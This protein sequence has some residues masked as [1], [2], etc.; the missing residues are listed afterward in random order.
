MAI[1]FS[2]LWH[3]TP[4][5][6]PAR[7]LDLMHGHVLLQLMLVDLLVV[8]EVWHWTHNTLHALLAVTSSW[9]AGPTTAIITHYCPRKPGH[10]VTYVTQKVCSDAPCAS[11]AQGSLASNNCI[12]D[13]SAMEFGKFN[14]HWHM[15][16]MLYRTLCCWTH[17]WLRPAG[18]PALQ[19]FEAWNAA[20]L[21]CNTAA[22]TCYAGV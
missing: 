5:F 20:L 14:L 1:F 13:A 10:W 16:M 12:D 21:G 22:S 7:F 8:R 9:A 4:N 2:F 3:L 11:N 17:C 15:H 19:V 6:F 18:R